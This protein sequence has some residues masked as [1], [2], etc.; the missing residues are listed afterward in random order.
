MR[1]CISGATIEAVSNLRGYVALSIGVIAISWS[2][3]FIRW[4]PMPGSASAFYRLLFASVLLCPYVALTHKH[5]HFSRKS[6]WLAAV[7]GAFFAADLSLYS[8]AVLNSSAANA[9]VLGNNTPIFV[10]FLAWWVTKKRPVMAFWTGLAIAL[11]GSILIVGQDLLHHADFGLADLLAVA[12]S[13]CFAVY[14]YVTEKMREE[15]DAATLLALS[16][17]ASTVTLL[18]FNV[19]TG[20]SLRIPDRGAWLAVLA[21]ALV[22]Q[23]LGYF[24]LTYAL[25]HLSAGITSVT[26]LVQ[27]PLTGFLAYLFLREPVTAAQVAGGI[28]VLLGVWIV[29]RYSRRPTILAE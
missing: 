2:A 24:S 15:F 12:A 13:G 17:F 1:R 11:S 4:A 29:N 16:L 28:L 25:G 8:T 14:L 10:G 18:I 20:V 3:I 27:A 7:G 21:L 22:C 26:L 5:P 19:G 6:L 23:L 9:T